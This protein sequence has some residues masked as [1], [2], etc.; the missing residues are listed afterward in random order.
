MVRL[1]AESKKMTF[2]D[3]S[4]A[5][6]PLATAHDDRSHI[7]HYEI[8]R[9]CPC[10]ISMEWRWRQVKVVRQHKKPEL[11]CEKSWQEKK[12]EICPQLL[13]RMSTLIFHPSTHP[14]PKHN[15]TFRKACA[16]P[17]R[18]LAQPHS[19]GLGDNCRDGI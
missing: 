12:T 19:G 16:R 11:T 4:L 15:Q 14:N 5:T 18:F 1:T 6:V 3:P 2:S 17:S 13:G 7:N 9:V 8:L 10:N